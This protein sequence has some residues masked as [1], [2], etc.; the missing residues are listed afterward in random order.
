ML[1]EENEDKASTAYQRV[2]AI[3]LDLKYSII[4]QASFFYVYIS[5]RMS[6]EDASTINQHEVS[7]SSIVLC[8]STSIRGPELMQTVLQIADQ[9]LGGSCTVLHMVVEWIYMFWPSLSTMKVSSDLPLHLSS[10]KNEL[11]A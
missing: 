4:Y 7:P 11:C 2:R 5:N 8:V 10:N 1:Q 6:F 3:R 9:T